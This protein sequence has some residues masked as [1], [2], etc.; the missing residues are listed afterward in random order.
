MPGWKINDCFEPCN[1]D[2]TGLH[3][4]RLV[5]HIEALLVIIKRTYAATQKISQDRNMVA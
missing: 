5:Y 2:V 1:T 4:L 3:L